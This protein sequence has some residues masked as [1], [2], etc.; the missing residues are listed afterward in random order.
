MKPNHMTGGNIGRYSQDS[1]TRM[2]KFNLVSQS[3]VDMLKKAAG[4]KFGNQLWMRRVSAIGAS[5]LG[6]T[7]LAQLGFGKIS[8]PHNVQKKQVSDDNNN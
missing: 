7:L 2:A 8:N 1:T 4:R 5:V 3:P 6:V